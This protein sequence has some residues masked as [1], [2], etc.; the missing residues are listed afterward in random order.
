MRS[1]GLRRL[2]GSFTQVACLLHLHAL[3]RGKG[4]GAIRD[5]FFGLIAH[6]MKNANEDLQ[7]PEDVARLLVLRLSSAFASKGEDF[8]VIYVNSQRDIAAALPWQVRLSGAYATVREVEA[9]HS[10][11]FL[12]RAGTQ[13]VNRTRPESHRLQ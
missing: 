10:F 2:L 3:G 11:M 6:I 4:Q 5:A 8:R 7:T 1:L 9:P 12:P 13:V